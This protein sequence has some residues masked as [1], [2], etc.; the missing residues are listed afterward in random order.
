MTDITWEGTPDD[1]TAKVGE[2]ELHLWNGVDSNWYWTLDH[3]GERIAN[4][5]RV[6]HF[7]KSSAQEACIKA[8]LQHINGK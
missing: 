3:K 8:Y 5:W 2:Y 4:G 6:N 1:L 7:T